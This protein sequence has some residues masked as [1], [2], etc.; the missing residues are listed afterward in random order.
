MVQCVGF[1]YEARGLFRTRLDSTFERKRAAAKGEK[2]ASI[3]LLT[4]ETRTKALREQPMCKFFLWNYWI[5]MFVNVILYI[6]S[7]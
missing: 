3:I 2:N 7:R 1:G 5:P 4:P 6:E